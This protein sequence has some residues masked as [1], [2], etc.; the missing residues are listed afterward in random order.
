MGKS[1][2]AGA[3]DEPLVIVQPVKGAL[4]L[5]ALD[6]QALALGL[7]PGL[8]LADARARFPA[9]V[10]AEH[11]PEADAGLLAWAARICARFSPLVALDPPDGLLLDV[12]GCAHLFGGE[13]LLRER[14]VHR[15]RHAGLGL[16]AALAGT[17]DCARALARHGKAGVVPPGGEEAA[18]RP[19]PVAALGLDAA[20]RKALALAGLRRIGDLAERPSRPLVAR[21]GEDLAVRLR[22]VLGREDRRIVPL[23][24][25]PALRVEEAFAEPLLD[26]GAIE[27][28][29]E[30]LAARAAERM[31]RASEG[32]R[33]F[34]ASFFRTDDAVRHVTVETSRPCRDPGTILRLFREKLD[35]LA[36]P[37]D[38][39]FGYDLIRLSVLQA[40]PLAAVQRELDGGS[41]SDDALADLV[42]R[43]VARFGP[44]R[45]LRFETV[46]THD[47][48]RA[49]PLVTVAAAPL[50]A[51]PET[52]PGEPP[53]RPLHLIEP[54]QPVE[55]LAEVPDGPPL[56][57]RW[58]RVLHDV[59][60]AEGP[61]RIACEWWR[62]GTGPTRDYFRVEDGQGRRFW[63]FREG[64]YGSETDR[65]RWFI[66]GLFA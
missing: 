41:A 52:E 19:L 32:G 63:L 58:R 4:R 64:L 54:P 48:V 29:L 65:P 45:V 44:A 1:L 7:K 18:V 39:G 49:A 51:F 27:P 35:A 24:P 6:R 36:D 3:P 61:E 53:L 11:D 16:R 21:F 22:R 59:T 55:A 37:L 17:P 47:P 12:T 66:H 34:E 56:R 33:S 62:G 38:P 8:T 2:P 43:L 42:D 15:F 5:A 13:T 14:A 57:F 60:R 25:A 46:D 40:E 50:T 23:R 26:A 28:V 20:T 31:E 30:R 10:V 9:L